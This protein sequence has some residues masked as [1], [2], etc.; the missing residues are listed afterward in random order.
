MQD[1]GNIHLN[2]FELIP[3]GISLDLIPANGGMN[4]LLPCS[5]LYP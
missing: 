5:P 1:A 3:T 4:R 2:S